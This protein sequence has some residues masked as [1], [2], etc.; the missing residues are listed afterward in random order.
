MRLFY[1]DEFEL[2]LPEGSKF[3]LGKYRLLRERLMQCGLA[4]EHNLFVPEAATDAQ[5]MLAHTADYVMRVRD[6]LR[7]V[8]QVSY[9]RRA[10]T[11]LA[12]CRA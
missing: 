1:T 3:P 10:R 5:L 4:N 8:Q 2:P 12:G 6:G 9:A 7:P 11:V